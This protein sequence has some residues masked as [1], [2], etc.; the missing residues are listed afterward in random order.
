MKQYGTGLGLAA[1]LAGALLCAGW[2]GDAAARAEA[3]PTPV[4]AACAP[5]ALIEALTDTLGRQVAPQRPER[6]VEA[7]RRD[8]SPSR[9]MAIPPF[10]LADG[11]CRQAVAPAAA[12][13]PI[14]A[15]STAMSDRDVGRRIFTGY[16]VDLD[17]AREFTHRDDVIGAYVDL[18]DEIQVDPDICAHHAGYDARLATWEG[19]Q[20]KDATTWIPEL[21]FARGYL[22]ELC[23]GDQAALDLYR[24]ATQAGDRVAHDRLLFIIND[25]V[26]SA[27]ADPH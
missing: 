3:Q 20:T 18:W 24:R 26:P 10:P 7:A 2:A 12:S 17:C 15:L 23:V 8:G 14:A 1:T 9:P 4:E 11:V 21:T 27:G 13:C 6:I 25:R 5:A 19:A 16:K 22:A